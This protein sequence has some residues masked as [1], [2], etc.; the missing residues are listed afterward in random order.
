M[1]GE[2][3]SALDYI[4]FCCIILSILC[5]TVRSILQWIVPHFR[6]APGLMQFRLTVALLAAFTTWL[7]GSYVTDQVITCRIFAVL[8]YFAFLSVF[9][10]M[11]NIAIDTWRLFGSNAQLLNPDETASPSLYYYISGWLLPLILTGT[12]LSLDYLPVATDYRPKF[13]QPHCWML[14]MSLIYYFF[15]PTGLLI[16]INIVLFI[17]TSRALYVSFKR[18]DAVTNKH[19]HDF[20]VTGP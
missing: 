10:W 9:A 13:G 1:Y 8:R 18:S 16:F 7:I 4:T 17:L 5:L 14:G 15:I 11:T 3:K 6:S 19:N 12:I 2:R 20:K